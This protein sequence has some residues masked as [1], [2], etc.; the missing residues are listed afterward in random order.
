M[1][2]KGTKAMQAKRKCI[3]QRS[4]DSLVLELCDVGTIKHTPDRH[5]GL[6]CLGTG[7]AQIGCRWRYSM[8]YCKTHNVCVYCM[9]VCREKKRPSLPSRLKL[10]Q[11]TIEEWEK[12]KKNEMQME[13]FKKIFDVNVKP[14][15][16]S[17]VL[18][19]S[20]H[21]LLTTFHGCSV[22]SSPQ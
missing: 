7:P 12:K 16:M 13:N 5:Y 14:C 2:A 20:L 4:F 9:C 1:D 11:T 18:F 22:S 6:C 3:Q 10:M 19:L 21:H 15:I 17:C 8:S